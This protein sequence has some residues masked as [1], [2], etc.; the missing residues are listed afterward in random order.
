MVVTPD[1][2]RS[3][4]MQ[5]S[6][7]QKYF[8]WESIQHNALPLWNRYLGN[9]FPMLAEGQTGTFFL[10]NLLLAKFTDPITLYNGGLVIAFIMLG[11]GMYLFISELTGLFIPAIFAGLSYMVSGLTYPHLTHITL[12]ET[13]SLMPWIVWITLKII[14]TQ[15]F[16]YFIWFA[17]LLTQQI[18]A[19]FIQAVFIT[20]CLCGSLY[21][22]EFFRLKLQLKSLVYFAAT[23]ILGLL[24]ALPQILPSAEF[25]KNL[26]ESKGY[27]VFTASSYSFPI[28][29]I[30]NLINPY[31]FGSPDNGTF[32]YDGSNIFWENSCYIGILGILLLIP[33]LCIY[34][35]W[36]LRDFQIIYFFMGILLISYLLMLGKNSP[37]YI[38]YTFWPFNLFRVPSR[39]IWTFVF[40]IITLGSLS[41]SFLLKKYTSNIFR[42]IVILL[43]LINTGQVFLTWNNYN[44][45]DIAAKW[46]SKPD[47]LNTIDNTADYLSIGT[48][49]T[50]NS[51][52]TA[53]GWQNIKPFY[54]LN[55]AMAPST[56][57]IWQ[58][59]SFQVTAGRLLKRQDITDSILLSDLKT[60][61]DIATVSSNIIKIM[62]IY[63]IKNVLSTIKISDN[64]VPPL[65]KKT[66]H[67]TNVDIFENNQAANTTYFST[68]IKVSKTVEQAKRIMLLDDFIPG[69]SV[70][71]ENQILLNA[72][73]SGNFR[74]INRSDTNLVYQIYNHPTSTMFVINNTYYP[75]W[76]AKIDGKITKILPAN[77]SKQ[78]IL[79]PKGNHLVEFTYQPQSVK[80]GLIIGLGIAIIITAISVVR[81]WF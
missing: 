66:S 77:I 23:V 22:F 15:K 67:Y 43:I 63:G 58:I 62:N 41:L 71:L 33:I 72:T 7:P 81:F 32:I 47:Y 17:F 18:F 69:K 16:K 28:N 64:T 10:P 34:R 60:Y 35:K 5:L 8:L 44:A 45:V 39:F 56:N 76:V 2:G 54:L 55:Q 52:Y 27:D 3:D 68:D 1:M 4:M 73:V 40:C 37:I 53:Q 19:G 57:M 48:I 12:L 61:G 70:L 24:M 75:G 14:K 36:K 49:H 38:I 29:G 30:V 42:F 25:L 65:T 79:I 21:L 78:A 20:L 51:T 9:G 50:H 46:I 13:F 74:L 11:M 80:F 26:F 6:F 31:F 59:P